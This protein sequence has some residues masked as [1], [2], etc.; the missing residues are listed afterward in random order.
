MKFFGYPLLLVIRMY[1]LLIP[2]N[3]RRRCI[4][5]ES[6]SKYVYRITVTEGIISGLKALRFRNRHC[7]GGYAVY[8]YN[9]RYELKTVYGLIVQQEDIAE[10][11]CK[12]G[13]AE[14]ID[15]DNMNAHDITKVKY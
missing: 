3:K 8:K 6:C 1:W 5:K 7:Q 2:A 14:V 12:E 15:F 10:H 11:L 9:G 13:N 4:F